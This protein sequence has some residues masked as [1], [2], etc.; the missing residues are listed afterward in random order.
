MKAHMMDV[1]PH[2]LEGIDDERWTL[3]D[4]IGPRKRPRMMTLA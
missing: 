4:I 1:E 2:M 3:D